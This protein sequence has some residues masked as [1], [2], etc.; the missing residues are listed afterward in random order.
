MTARTEGWGGGPRARLAVLIVSLA[1]CQGEAPA[2]TGSP[3]SG[4]GLA[5]HS[6]APVARATSQEVAG[7]LGIGRPATLQ[8]IRE[9]D[10]DVMGD[11][12]GLPPGSGTVA[13]GARVYAAQCATCHG[14]EGEG[15]P[16]DPLV[17]T[18]PLGPGVPRTIGNVWPYA[19][20]LFDY[21]RRAMP[22]DQPGSL[23]DHQVYAVVAWL[24]HRNEI[25]E[26]GVVLD[27][28]T[29]REVVMPAAALFVPDDR[30]GPPR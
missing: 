14:P 15:L 28:A 22:Q 29:L 26:E 2:D 6:P 24:L 20:T 30:L 10:M 12:A 8:E 21:I 18:T 7:P 16:S 23:S 1:G 9:W 5:L 4:A 27:A 17:G 11:G 19:P 25:V 3:G 13:E